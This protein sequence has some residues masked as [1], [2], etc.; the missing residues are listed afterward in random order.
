M[1]AGELVRSADGVT[2][3]DPSVPE[4]AEAVNEGWVRHIRHVAL[5]LDGDVLSVFYSRI[6]DAPER[7]MRATARLSGPW[8]EWR[9]ADPV[10]ILRPATAWEGADLPV[11]PSRASVARAPGNELRDPGILDYGGRRYLYYAYRGERGIG[12]AELTSR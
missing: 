12:V 10:E 11:H 5:A 2:W 6:G 4:F 3:S 1:R 8:T 7:I 9:L